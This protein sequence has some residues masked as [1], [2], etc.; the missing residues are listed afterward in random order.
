MIVAGVLALICG[1]ATPFIFRGLIWLATRLAGH[2]GQSKQ[3]LGHQMLITSACLF[4]QLA[5]ASSALLIIASAFDFAVPVIAIAFMV[6]IGLSR[7][8]LKEI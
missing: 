5:L 1:V 7:L 3:R 6:G 2:K 8:L 4:I